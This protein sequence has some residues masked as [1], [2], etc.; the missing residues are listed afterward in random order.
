MAG[1]RF[2]NNTY[3]LDAAFTAPVPKPHIP[4]LITST[5]GPAILTTPNY[6]HRSVVVPQ[7][8]PLSFFITRASVIRHECRLRSTHS[9]PSQ[10][11]PG[12][13]GPRRYRP[14][15][16]AVVVGSTLSFPTQLKYTYSMCCSCSGLVKNQGASEPHTA[17]WVSSGMQKSPA[18]ARLCLVRQ[19]C[20][21]H[22]I[23]LCGAPASSRGDLR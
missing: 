9:D 22:A 23:L 8:K 3:R 15:W 19:Y 14:Y 20:P 7:G 17:C 10:R 1:C 12:L 16:R 18:G 21:G 2:Q 5:T 6:G 4:V 13:S 11:A